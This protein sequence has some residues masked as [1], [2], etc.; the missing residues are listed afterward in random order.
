MGLQEHVVETARRAGKMHDIGKLDIPQTLLNSPD[1]LTDE[2]D[3]LLKTHPQSSYKKLLTVPYPEHL[4]DVPLVAG[5]H[6]ERL[7]GSGYG[8][9][10][11]AQIPIETRIVSVADVIDAM[12]SKRSYQGEIPLM[13]TMAYIKQ[14]AGILFDCDVVSAV[15]LIAAHEFLA[16][17]T[18]EPGRPAEIKVRDFVEVTS[19]FEGSH[20]VVAA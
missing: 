10:K 9:L 13:E 17:M 16:V 5:A 6:H 20:Y 18:S 1:T 19:L 15:F 2:Q 4:Q 14:N 11:G 7:D 3:A 12:V 8:G